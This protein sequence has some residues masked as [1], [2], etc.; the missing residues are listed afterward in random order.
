LR[1]FLLIEEARKSA[2]YE[3]PR[4]IRL[5]R[6]ITMEGATPASAGAPIT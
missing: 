6:A 2:P 1:A 4:R 3:D 5:N